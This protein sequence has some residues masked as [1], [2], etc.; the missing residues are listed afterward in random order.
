MKQAH[1]TPP[2]EPPLRVQAEARLA[3][4]SAAGGAPSASASADRLVHE[5]QVHQIELEM[6]N[7]SLRDNQAALE[8]SLSRYVTLYDL[9]PVGYFTLT[10]EGLISEFN[11]LSVQLLGIA[12]NA[13]TPMHFGALLAASDRDRWQSSFAHLL[14]T[15]TRCSLDVEIQRPDGALVSGRLDAIRQG[16]PGGQPC[17]LVAL[18]DNSA[19]RQTEIELTTSKAWLRQLVDSIPDAIISADATQTIVTANLAAAEM[20]QCAQE[21]M[22]GASLARFMPERFRA[23]HRQ[24]M[25]AFG[26]TEVT[27][28]PMGR[29]R[30]VIG[31]RSNGEE[32]R[33]EAAISRHHLDGKPIYT[34]ILRDITDRRHTEE[35]LRSG[36]ATLEAA[37]S[38]MSDA[39]FISDAQGRFISVN[40]AFATFHRFASK[41]ECLMTLAEY[42][43]VLDV[44][45]ANGEPAPLDQWVVSRALRGETA[46]GVEYKLRRKDTS[47]SW[48]GSYSFAPIRSK[49][50]LIVGSVV[51][52]RDVTE[53]RQRQAEL[54]AAHAALQRLIT[55]QDR[56]QETERKRIAQDLHDDLQ[57]SLAAIRM[58]MGAIRQKISAA[59]DVAPLLGTV[60]QLV[61]AAITA[62]RRIVNDLQPQVLVDLGLVPALEVLAEQFSQRTGI[63]CEFESRGT[64]GDASPDMACV[65]TPLYRIAQEALNNVL[66]HARASAVRL[67]LAHGADGSLTLRIAD[68]GVGM[69]QGDRTKAQA[70]GLQGMRERV[71]ALGGTLRIESEMRAGTTVEVVVP[72]PSQAIDLCVAPSASR[73]TTSSMQEELD[74]APGNVAILDVQGNILFVNQAWREFAQANGD[75]AMI[76]TGPGVN[77]LAVCRRSAQSDPHSLPVL[78]GLLDIVHGRS[79]V[80]MSAYPCHSPREQRWFLLKFAAMADGHFK[81]THL[82]ISHL[83]DVG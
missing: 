26:T 80:F 59:Q 5:L 63:H 47:Q 75:P 49:D 11:L 78:Q 77:Y 34:A 55:A 16:T 56:V 66:K 31:L 64:T 6:L 27:S 24:D 52:G 37:L 83:A 19:R 1:H 41:D 14:M 23:G 21:E 51:T 60:D 46:T 42:P 4:R 30:D 68:N 81:V 36:K 53:Y 15:G 79:H 50:G 39:V 35:A 38:S 71:R 18:T 10:Q 2:P 69:S 82:D 25:Q 73:Q 74:A 20:F 48:T 40:E 67:Q 17:A 65:A 7:E 54:N 72:L 57:Q 13:A 44:F 29:S 32:F 9:A 43:Q 61:A 12:Q 45:L 22:V 33:I 28:R 62:T 58:D 76:A 3:D 70:F 8:A